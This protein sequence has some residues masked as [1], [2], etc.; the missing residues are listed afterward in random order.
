MRPM[1]SIGRWCWST[2]GLGE[3]SRS[4]TYNG[5]KDD[6]EED[7]DEEE[8]SKEEAK[9]SGGLAARLSFLSLENRLVFQLSKKHDCNHYSLRE[10]DFRHRSQCHHTSHL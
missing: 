9:V 2:F 1:R 3:N 7:G 8:L 5:N 6:K 10:L 4:L